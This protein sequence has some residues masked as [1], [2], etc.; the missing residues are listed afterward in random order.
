MRVIKKKTT[1]SKRR[2][3]TIYQDF[4]FEAAHYLPHVPDD[5]KC[6][7]VHGHSYLVRVTLEGPERA[8][9]GWVE[10]FGKVEIV[11]GEW[12]RAL[13]H[14]LINDVDDALKNPTSEMLAVWLWGKV[15]PHFKATLKSIEVK[16]TADSGAIFHGEFQ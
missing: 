15:H 2:Q 10:D 14:R 4:K 11:V 6:R 16:E 7:R 13:D 5:H 3:F 12:I 8:A 9:R 1:R